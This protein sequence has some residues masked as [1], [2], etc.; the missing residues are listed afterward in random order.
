L[1][2]LSF[3]GVGCLNYFFAPPIYSF[4]VDYPQDLITISAFVITSLVINF[5]VTRVRVEQRDHMRT[6]ETLRDANQQLEVTNNAWRIENVER[7]RA[8]QALRESEYKLRQLFET[9]PG[10]IWSMDSYGSEG[11][12]ADY[13]GIM[14]QVQAILN[15]LRR[16]RYGTAS[17]SL[18]AVNKRQARISLGFRKIIP[19][20]SASTL[21]HSGTTGSRFTR[22]SKK[23]DANTG[24]TACARAKGDEHCYRV[25]DAQDYRWFLTRA[26]PLRASDG[27]LLLWIGT[28]EY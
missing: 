7:K 24:Q 25:R 18:T 23:K 20:V 10:L 17:G 28:T 3:I 13:S 9:E 1:I 11:K 5:L 16:M 19:C 8:E 22:T 12:K 26:V 4:R 21:A 14:A 15:V 27:T 6:C 2:V